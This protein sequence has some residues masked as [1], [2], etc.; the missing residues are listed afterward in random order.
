MLVVY[1]HDYVADRD[2]HP[3][4]PA[5]HHRRMLQHVTLP[6]KIKIQGIVSTE[7]VPLSHCQKVRN[8]KLNQYKLRTILEGLVGKVR[9]EKYNKKD[10]LIGWTQH[11]NGGNR[12]NNH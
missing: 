2:L 6:G 8:G 9:T 10:K 7:Y 4:A 11:Q 1:P 5:Q 3:T 12:R